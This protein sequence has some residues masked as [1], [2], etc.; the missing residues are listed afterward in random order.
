[1]MSQRI[2]SD[3]TYQVCQDA[4]IASAFLIANSDNTIVSA[5]DFVSSLTTI[6]VLG[7]ESNTNCRTRNQ[8]EC[9]GHHVR[10]N[11]VLYCSWEL[12][13]IDDSPSSVPFSAPD[14]SKRKPVTQFKSKKATDK[15][16]KRNTN[17]H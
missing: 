3:A 8:H 10:V 1:M 13:T 6:D 5:S 14:Q 11:D 16:N 9:C 7:V 12:Q 17:S 15:R 4:P 2:D